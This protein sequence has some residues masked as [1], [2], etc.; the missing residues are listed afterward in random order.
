MLD[1]NAIAHLNLVRG[2]DGHLYIHDPSYKFPW[3]HHTHIPQRSDYPYTNN[4]RS[5]GLSGLGVVTPVEQAATM[6]L[7]FI[8]GVGPI[9]AGVAEIAEM[10][11]GGGDPTPLSTYFKDLVKMRLE[12]AQAHDA[13]GVSDDFR[14]PEGFT[15][16]ADEIA[17]L[18]M[19]IV[20]EHYGKYTGMTTDQI[21]DLDWSGT[22]LPGTP[23][24]ALWPN[25]QGSGERGFVMNTLKAIQSQ[26]S[27]ASIGAAND[28]LTGTQQQAVS[29]TMVDD[30]TAAGAPPS[31]SP[32]LPPA[33]SIMSVPP[34]QPSVQD[35]SQNTASDAQSAP[36]AAGMTFSQEMGNY[37][38]WALVGLGAIGVLLFAA[39]SGSGR[40]R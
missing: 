6:A 34:P 20:N 10:L 18:A 1:Y 14:L 4:S 28:Q 29:N 30:A 16:T 21:L 39:S 27:S 15:G 24:V 7:A 33:S 35:T 5:R 19:L 3:A 22:S 11:L 12:L 8:P 13:E 2:Q 25:Y 23:F 17:N 40:R 37:G 31:P 9:L 36:P 26:L 32:V 38:P